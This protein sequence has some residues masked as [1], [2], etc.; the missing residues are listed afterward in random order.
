MKLS[1]FVLTGLLGM[2]TLS[3]CTAARGPEY[4]LGIYEKDS[5]AVVLRAHLQNIEN[6][7]AAGGNTESLRREVEK[8]TVRY[9]NFLEAYYASAVFARCRKELEA[10]FVPSFLQRVDEIPKTA[11][12]KPQERFLLE[13]FDPEAA[14]VYT[15]T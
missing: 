12:E 7:D 5:P 13:R 1:L 14:D 6:I 8:M 10:N 3:S 9:P 2:M 4:A 15:L 11:S